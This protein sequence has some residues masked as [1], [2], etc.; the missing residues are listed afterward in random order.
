MDNRYYKIYK[1]TNT[2]NG[3]CYI[4]YTINTIERRFL[5]H[6][7][8]SSECT[9]LHKAIHKY[10]E[11]NFDLEEICGTKNKEFIGELE[12]YFI[13]FYNTLAP[14]GYNLKRGGFNGDMSEVTKKK[15]SQSHIKRWQGMTEEQRTSATK[16]I[17]E[18]VEEKKTALIAVN[19]DNGNISKFDSG[20]EARNNNFNPDDCLSG[21]T[22]QNNGYVWF[23]DEGHSDDHYKQLASDKIGGFGNYKKN[24]QWDDPEHRAARTAAIKAGHE[25]RKRPIIGISRF[26]LSPKEFDS[27]Q[28]ADQAGLK[29][30][31]I[32]QSLTR[33]CTHAYNYCWFYKD[34]V[35]SLEDAQ[36]QAKAILGHKFDPTNIKP[37]LAIHLKTGATVTYSNLYEAEKHGFP[38]KAIRRV[39][40]GDRSS[41]KGFSFSHS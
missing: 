25:Y 40:R 2:I 17:K 14:N 28:D 12:D 8:D 35:S 27:I 3:R 22:T 41:L 20:I 24:H 10:G 5:S 23:Y 30:G 26:D 13:Q 6:V 4:G 29:L 33:K 1:L 38:I 18:Y 32:H 21:K 7:N 34:S 31:S 19:I 16:A 15:M 9:Y 39:L 11:E 36:T 37:V